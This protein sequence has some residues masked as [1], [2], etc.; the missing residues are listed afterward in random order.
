M[1]GKLSISE[2]FFYIPYILW[3]IIYIL[4][5]TLYIYKFD[6][7]EIMK[8]VR[9]ISFTIL[10]LKIF[11][12]NLY[13][14]KILLKFLLV[15]LLLMVIVFFSGQ[16]LLLDTFLFIFC[17]RNILFKDIIK[18]TLIIHIFM[19]I[20]IILSNYFGI[21]QDVNVWYR[22]DGIIRYAL[23]YNYC[24]LVAQYYFHI[25]LMFI[26]LKDGKKLKLIETI[27][28]L[29]INYIIY[30]YTDTRAVF[31]LICILI[32]LTYII[33]FFDKPLKNG[34]I[35][36]LLFKYCFPISALISIIG[37]IN[38]DKSN[39]IY[40]VLNKLFS[41]RLDLGLKGYEQ[42]GISWFGQKIQWITGA[43]SYDT[44]N[45]VDSS[46]L[47]IALNYGIILLIIL[48]IVFVFIGKFAIENNKKYFCLVLMFLA[49]HS[50]TDP[51]LIEL[52]YNPFLLTF[53][54]FFI[55]NF[56]ISLFEKTKLIKYHNKLNINNK[57]LVDYNLQK[58]IQ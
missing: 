24:T 26:V 27:L 33:S 15:G 23:G 5:D 37:S 40:L 8:L 54:V 50:I 11:Y 21:I 56:K 9:I 44:Y 1:K 3:S 34:I 13:S 4:E 12:D 35:S 14:I 6:V 10:V 18:I 31:F 17:A 38:Y 43:G 42:F 32:P 20:F 39:I 29:I 58:E 7:H 28:I 55:S 2:L 22:D 19:I 52:R 30:I 45:Y 16:T 49:V 53:S 36:K 25:I 51:Q 41:G 46:Y 48:C 57:K 47:K